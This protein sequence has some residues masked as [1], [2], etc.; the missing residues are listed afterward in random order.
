[1]RPRHVAIDVHAQNAVQIDGQTELIAHLGY[2]TESF[3][4]PMIYNPY[5]ERAGINAVV[6]PMGVPGRR[7]S[8]GPAQLCSRWTNIRGALVT[9]PHKVSDGRPARRGHADRE[10]SR[11]PATRSGAAPTAG[12]L[13]DMFDGEGFVRGV[14]AQGPASCAGARALVVGSGGVGSAIAA[15][16]AG[17]GVAEHRA[18]RRQAGRG[19]GVWRERLRT[20]YPAL[21]VATGRNDPGGLRPGRQRDAAGHE[22]RRPAAD[23]RDRASRRA[24]SSAKS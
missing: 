4:A 3:K 9:M 22:R 5:F 24:P 16:L 14:A 20:H 6:V 8:A 2:P 12:S 17:A 15:S 19:R 10:A 23:G 11:A 7:L 18:V 21:D 1:M 13:G